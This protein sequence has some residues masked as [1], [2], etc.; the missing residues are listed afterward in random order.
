M[1][2]GL[3]FL[4]SG[5]LYDSAGDERLFYEE[6]DT[7]QNNNGI[8]R[9]LDND[10]FGSFFGSVS[11]R[12]FTLQGAFID[13]EKENPTAQFV[14]ANGFNQPGLE[15]VDERSYAN[16]KYAH[17]FTDVV[18]ITA[19]IY[20]DRNDFTIGYPL[21]IPG[22]ITNLS[23]E[24]ATGEWWGAE[25]QLNKRLWDRHIVTLGA[26]YRDDFRQD[27][28]LATQ[29]SEF[30]VHRDQQSHGVYAQGDF[31]VLT[32]L[33]VNAGVR[34]D[35]YGDFDATI[36][37]RVAA[38]YNPLEKSTFKAIYGTGFRA[39]N[40]LE[41]ALSQPD[42][43]EPEEITTY[44]LVYEQEIGQHWRSSVSA[45][46]NDMDDLIVFE[47]GFT[48]FDATTKG[49]EL[50]LAG[51]WTNGISGRASYTLQETENRS[52]DSDFPDSPMH[53]VKLNV[54]APLIRE[55]LFAGLEFQYTSSRETVFTTAGG[56]RMAG[57]DV[58]GF[59]IVNFTLF[60]L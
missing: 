14:G 43:L 51:D 45:F 4:L 46:Y 56:Q 54:C 18:D 60:R 11:Y 30:E 6:F 24:K 27:R 10:S 39:P 19:Q 52:T 5:T 35:Q 20:Y 25:L 40:F 48:N 15:T 9:K 23:K 47:N 12:D 17:D 1:L 42:E 2:D 28:R 55:K 31:G 32:N 44:E 38:I 36:N 26:E 3:Q 22:V 21:E 33:H 53:L 29:G 16:L 59:G 49:I 13:R 50:A 7:P 57:K 37:P 58:S 34:Y 8:A 41:L